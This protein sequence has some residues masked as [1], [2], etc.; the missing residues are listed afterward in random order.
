[1]RRKHG[2][3]FAEVMAIIEQHGPC[4]NL[5]IRERVAMSR[6]DIHTHCLRGIQKGVLSVTKSDTGINT[7]AA[8]VQK[9]PS[10]RVRVASVWQ[11]GSQ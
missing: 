5:E 7:Y 3:A 2:T 9:P 11:L 8:A 4:T 10:P 1:M 6:L